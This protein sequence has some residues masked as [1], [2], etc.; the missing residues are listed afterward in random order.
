LAFAP[1][2]LGGVKS[3]TFT[4]EPEIAERLEKLCRITKVGSSELINL[5][6]ESPLEQVFGLGDTSLLRAYIQPFIHETKESAVEVIAGYE[7]FAAE[8]RAAGDTCCVADAKRRRTREDDWEVVFK[9]TH[10]WD[11]GEARYQ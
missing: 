5:L 8:L 9:S 6:L 11:E 4:A 10:P 1:D 7:A 3:I 2:I